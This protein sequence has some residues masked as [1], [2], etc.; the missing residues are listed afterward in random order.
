MECWFTMEPLSDILSGL[1]NLAYLGWKQWKHVGAWHHWSRLSFSKVGGGRKTL[2]LIKDGFYLFYLSSA[3]LWERVVWGLVE[4]RPS[5]PALLWGRAWCGPPGRLT[6][7]SGTG[8][9]GRPGRR[10]EGTAWGTGQDLLEQ[11][12]LDS[13]VLS[14]ECGR[15]TISSVENQLILLTRR[16][17]PLIGDPIRCNSTIA[18]QDRKT[19]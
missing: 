13:F 1:L 10:G 19:V 5:P 8:S 3:Y 7:S 11:S 14:T 12:L 9:E 2:C 17:C 18:L 16:V 15:N 6:G 4:Q